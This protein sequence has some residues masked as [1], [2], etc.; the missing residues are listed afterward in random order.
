MK[1]TATRRAVLLAAATG[2]ALLSPLAAAVVQ[3][4]SSRNEDR[5]PGEEKA[6]GSVE[7]LMREHG[8]LRRILL[9]YD[10]TAD[11]LRAGASIDLAPLNRAARLFRS[12][13][14][15]YH[16]KMLEEAF[17]FPTLRK[18]RGPAAAYADILT[19]QHH[20]GR[21]ITNYLLETTARHKI[22]SSR[23]AV[24]AHTFDGFVS[25][26]RNHAARED[27]LVF[28]AWKQALA[29][30]QL[31]ELGDQFEEIEQQQFG[32]E[33]FDT[34]VDEIAA[35]E[36]ALGYGDLAQFTAPLPPSAS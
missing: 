30:R 26:Y 10:Q 8:V 21:V 22:S 15:D 1:N 23:A 33:G 9:V 4:D 34:T 20:R 35:I 19:A 16:E 6:V 17:I 31:D 2:S 5:G 3:D 25:M 14:E 36:S 32:K 27:T 13:G 11:R 24:L 18:V 7:D 12:F 28:P 29:E